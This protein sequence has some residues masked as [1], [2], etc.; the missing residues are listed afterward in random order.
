MGSETPFI[1]LS[2]SG[3]LVAEAGAEEL[4]GVIMSMGSVSFGPDIWMV[5]VR[6]GTVRGAIGSSLPSPSPRCV[7]CG[8][9]ITCAI[10]A[11]GDKTV[12]IWS[13]NSIQRGAAG[14]W[15]WV[16]GGQRSMGRGSFWIDQRWEL[17]RKSIRTKARRNTPHSSRYVLGEVGLL[18]KS[19]SVEAVLLCPPG[20]RF[21]A[22]SRRPGA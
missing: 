2:L 18:A 12:S 20:G 9:S 11:W 15:A 16:S 3:L 13:R 21:A 6:M 8:L 10:C 1:S 19:S 14:W 17:G 4:V 22:A 7:L 5:G